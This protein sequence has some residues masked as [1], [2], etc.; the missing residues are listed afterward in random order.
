MVV[1]LVDD[2]GGVNLHEDAAF[3]W[4]SDSLLLFLLGDGDF[5]FSYEVLCHD[6]FTVGGEAY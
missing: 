4:N 3:F 2:L 6:T 1:V 5:G